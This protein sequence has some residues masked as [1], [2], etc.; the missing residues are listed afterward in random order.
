[1]KNPRTH[2]LWIGG[3]LI[4][5]LIPLFFAFRTYYRPELDLR[6]QATRPALN[7]AEGDRLLELGLEDRFDLSDTLTLIQLMV[8]A[9]RPDDALL[10]FERLHNRFS[11]V[12]G[13]ALWYAHDLR[14]N[15]R[16]AEAER[17]YLAIANRMDEVE[18]ESG[19]DFTRAQDRDLVLAYRRIGLPEELLT[20][21]PREIQQYL[22]ENALEAGLEASG[23]SRSLWLSK[24]REYLEK[25]LSMDPDHAGARGVYANLLLQLDQ[26][27]A[28]LQQY[29]RLLEQ[30]PRNVGWL[31]AAAVSAAAGDNF[32]LAA[33]Y[34]RDVLRQEDRAAWRLEYARHLSWGG[35]H[36]TALQEIG[37]L[38]AEDP[39]NT[40]YLR[41]YH[42]FLL[43]A[44]RY[45]QFLDST[46]RWA[47]RY[48][49]D[50][51]L[52]LERMRVMMGLE[53]YADALREGSSILALDPD[54]T[55]AALLEG[56]ALLWMGDHA[57]A[58]QHL[59]RLVERDPQPR[60]RKR[61]AQSYLWGGRPQEALPQFRRLDPG[62]INDVEVAQGYAEALAV[63][64]HLPPDDVTTV[65][66]MKS[67]VIANRDAEWPTPLLAAMGRVLA[68]AGY[69]REALTLMQAAG[70]KDPGNLRMQLELADL[71]Q[72]LGDHDE[73]D[74]LYRTILAPL[75]REPQQ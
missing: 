56:E 11:D 52:R 60:I 42:Q 44:G 19:V 22:G 65:R 54:H 34:M 31:V 12:V 67:R 2:Y 39:E 73:A 47:A 62:R 23:Q 75:E 33:N 21:E 66:N 1:M 24:S 57:S 32:E 64:E 7:P 69:P 51:D 9:D 48:P 71:L 68:R 27:L 40:D 55:E 20:V 10:L 46:E 49:E 13:I 43:N 3:V 8:Q 58:Q 61:L 28:S 38:I 29:Q 35:N 25:A 59:S 6:M 26:P 45:P 30:E 15:E 5:L 41:E 63:A 36:E 70:Q 53:R 18:R 72:D 16:W 14:E 17:V 50:F 74:R 37:L 4:A